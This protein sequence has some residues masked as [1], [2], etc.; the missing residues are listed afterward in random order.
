M[1]AN[2]DLNFDYSPW[3]FQAAASADSRLFAIGDSLDPIHGTVGKPGT[4]S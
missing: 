2:P 4:V 1:N 3:T